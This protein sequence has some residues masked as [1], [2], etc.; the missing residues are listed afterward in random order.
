MKKNDLFVV[1]NFTPVPHEKYKVG[2]PKD[3]GR[4][5]EVLN[6]DDQKYGGSGIKSN[7]TQLIEKP[8]HGHEQ[9]VELTVPPLSI[10]VFR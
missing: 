8:G 6:S 10:V 4:I 2:V 1:C 9:S 3:S 7:L 5:I